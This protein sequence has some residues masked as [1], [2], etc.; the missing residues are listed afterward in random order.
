VG[1]DVASDYPETDISACFQSF[2]PDHSVP[3]SPIVSMNPAWIGELLAP[4]P[5]TSMHTHV[6]THV[7]RCDFPSL[8]LSP[9]PSRDW[10]LNSVNGCWINEGVS[11]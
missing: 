5:N 3:S 1:S 8:V 2:S 9:R 4:F 11:D 10:Q 7:H 6:H